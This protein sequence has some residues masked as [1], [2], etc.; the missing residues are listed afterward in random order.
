MFKFNKIIV[1]FGFISFLF[2][3]C[4]GSLSD[5]D[6]ILKARQEVD[7]EQFSQALNDLS[8]VR[9]QNTEDVAFLKS[10]AY[11]G[12]AG[13]RAF[14]IYD[15]VYKNQKIK[16]PFSLFFIL[17]HN[18]S[19][20]DVKNSRSSITSIEKFN[21]DI[22]SR[23]NNLNISFALTEFYKVSQII[24]F[25]A[26]LNHLGQVSKNWNPCS[27]VDFPTADVRE[28]IV[29]LNKGVIALS[30]IIKNFH[31]ADLQLIFDLI[32]EIQHDIGIDTGVLDENAVQVKD[33]QTLR[34][35]INR[36]VLK[37]GNICN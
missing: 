3:G 28:T 9:N 1:V 13:F 15:I 19:T 34:T 6:L 18:H 20:E 27:E 10:S 8:A 4:G 23:S 2:G 25:D 29:S 31:E 32:N 24:L 5:A 26:D 37:N 14:E 17:S 12:L 11:A 7:Q 35:F 36:D 16:P 21:L 30:Q 22:A 33:V